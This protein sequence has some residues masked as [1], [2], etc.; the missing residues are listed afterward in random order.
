VK[1]GSAI[2]TF[3]QFLPDLEKEQ[4]LAVNM[5]E[6]AGLGV[7]AFIAIVTFHLETAKAPNFDAFLLHQGISHVLKNGVD[8]HFGLLQGNILSFG[9][10][11]DE[12]RLVYPALLLC[13]VRR[14]P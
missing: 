5:D 9:Q 2:D 8:H 7:T 14:G 13:G 1:N 11:F 4:F 3:P 12:L 6:I 10:S